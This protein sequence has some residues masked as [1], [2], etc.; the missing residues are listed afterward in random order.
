MLRDGFARQPCDKV[1]LDLSHS[2]LPGSVFGM[3]ARFC[4]HVEHPIAKPLLNIFSRYEEHML[5]I[6]QPAPSTLP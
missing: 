4:V 2:L 1:F 3:F 6:R 5:D